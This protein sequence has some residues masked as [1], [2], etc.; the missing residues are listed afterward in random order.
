M[1]LVSLQLGR[2]SP[3]QSLQKLQP[4]MLFAS[5]VGKRSTTN[6]TVESKDSSTPPRL[7]LQNASTEWQLPRTKMCTGRAATTLSVLS[8]DHQKTTIDTGPRTQNIIRAPTT[9][10]TAMERTPWRN[11]PRYPYKTRWSTNSKIVKLA[12]EISQKTS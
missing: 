1:L 10:T 8:T 4:R 11:G 9:V 5:H 12:I 3:R 7:R 2:N 6:E